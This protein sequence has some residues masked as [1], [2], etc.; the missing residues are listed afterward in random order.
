MKEVMRKTITKKD[1]VPQKLLIKSEKNNKIKTKISQNRK[2][3]KHM[4]SFSVNLVNKIASKTF[5]SKVAF[6]AYLN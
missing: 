4:N 2:T 3:A 5:L 1:S 6:K